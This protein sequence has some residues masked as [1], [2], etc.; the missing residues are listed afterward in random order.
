MSSKLES[1]RMTLKM[2]LLIA[3]RKSPYE[4]GIYPRTLVTRKLRDMYRD[5]YLHKSKR[6]FRMAP[7]GN[8]FL[9][10]EKI[11]ALTILTP[12]KW[13]RK[14]RMVLFDVPVI[15]G[16]QRNIFRAHLK[17]LGLVLYQHS[18]WVYPYPLGKTVRQISDFY[19]ISNC[20][21]FAVAEELNGENKLKEKFNLE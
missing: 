21:L 15:K 8:Y 7:R 18:V 5:G 20:V 12:K 16:K 19:K 10:K 3:D 4:T 14:W 2:L 6:I 1:A 11:W 9:Q 17:E 13:D